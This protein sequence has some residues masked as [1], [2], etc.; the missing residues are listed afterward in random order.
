MR[1]RKP[2]PLPSS[3]PSRRTT[4]CSRMC[5]YI[6]FCQ[7]EKPHL[8]EINDNMNTSDWS[9]NN[10]V[11]HPTHLRTF[12]TLSGNWS[13]T[14]FFNL[15]S[16][17]GRRTLCKR[18]IMRRDSSS[19]ISTFSPEAAKG[20]LNHSSKFSIELKIEGRRKL[21]SDHSSGRLFWSGVPVPCHI[22]CQGSAPQFLCHRA[23]SLP[24]SKRR[25]L[26]L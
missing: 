12:S 15:R 9:T 18:L 25:C 3:E 16:K 20:A 17:K 8:H 14:C 4:F 24:V 22:Q 26:A 6:R 5:L 10:E 13:S 7:A 1:P 19:L 23:A 21:S 2:P 11:S